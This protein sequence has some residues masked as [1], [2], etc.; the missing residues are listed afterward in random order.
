MI[1][2]INMSANFR[3]F[4]ELY[5]QKELNDVHPEQQAQRSDDLQNYVSEEEK[6]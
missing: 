1:A 3:D 2:M 4:F 5:K 6:R